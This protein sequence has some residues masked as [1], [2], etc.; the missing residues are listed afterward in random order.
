M[1]KPNIFRFATS[2]LSQ[3][4]A[5]CWL[6]AWANPALKTENPSL[7]QTAHDFLSSIFEAAG[8]KLPDCISS[9]EVMRQNG[10][11]DILCVLNSEYLIVIEDKTASVQHSNQLERYKLHAVERLKFSTEKT[12]LVYLQ[13]GDQGSYSEALKHGY[14]VL[15]RNAI[16]SIL[17]SPCGMAARSRSDILEDFSSHLRRKEDAV[18]SYACKKVDEWSTSSWK[19]FFIKLQDTLSEGN[20]RK[21]PNAGGGFMGFWYGSRKTEDCKLYVQL[22][23]KQLCFKVAVSQ[24]SNLKNIRKKWHKKLLEGC[25][26]LSFPVCRPDRFG[27]G[28][29][30]TVAV[31]PE[32]YRFTTADGII[33]LDRTAKRLAEARAVMDWCV[34]RT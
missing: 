22:E 21:V 28:A 25:A 5:I 11:I 3:D 9:L 18:Q 26:E 19:G 32:D 20:W 7:H 2:E 1:E 4:A 27:T 33:D 17:E 8:K 12:I 29:T 10:N 15:R 34:S 30:M 16:L 13:T 24:G 23:E 6:L 14:T 31:F